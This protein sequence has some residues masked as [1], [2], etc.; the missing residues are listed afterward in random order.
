MGETPHPVLIEW[1]GSMI[2]F[3]CF[4]QQEPCQTAEEIENAFGYVPI[5]PVTMIDA[6]CADGEY[7]DNKGNGL[8]SVNFDDISMYQGLSVSLGSK[9]DLNAG[10]LVTVAC[11]QLEIYYELNVHLYVSTKEFG[12]D[13]T[14]AT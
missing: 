4:C 1:V 8:E 14:E 12:L 3:S 7:P 6:P 10:N 5:Q 9:P 13:P 2:A 11:D